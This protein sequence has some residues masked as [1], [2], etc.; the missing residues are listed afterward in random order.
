MQE[1]QVQSPGLED[2]L[3]ESTATHSSIL[4][5]RIPWTE[6]PGGLQSTRLQRVRGNWSDWAHTH[7][8]NW[9]RLFVLT[10]YYCVRQRPQADHLN[11]FLPPSWTGVHF[12]I[13]LYSC[14]LWLGSRQRKVSG[15]R[16]HPARA[17]ALT[18]VMLLHVLSFPV[19]WG[20]NHNETTWETADS[21]SHSGPWDPMPLP[22]PWAP[23][24]RE[25]HIFRLSH[26]ISGA[27]VTIFPNQLPEIITWT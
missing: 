25:E 23:S 26:W 3:E 11:P 9:S 6:E 8:K 4:A 18:P 5:C 13:F 17:G 2:P 27:H 15:N 20:G 10:L 22:P 14:L 19:A 16:V 7:R 12:L 24:V 1:T 21:P